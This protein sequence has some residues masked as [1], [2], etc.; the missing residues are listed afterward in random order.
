MKRSFRVDPLKPRE[1]AH[2]RESNET[3][4]QATETPNE[5]EEDIKVHQRCFASFGL[6]SLSWTDGDGGDSDITDVGAMCMSCS[7]MQQKKVRATH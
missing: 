6:H 1:S 5:D 3:D 7:D 2:Q 4:P